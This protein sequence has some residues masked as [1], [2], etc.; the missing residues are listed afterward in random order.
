[1][2]PRSPC[3]SEKMLNFLRNI[4]I[5]KES[6]CAFDGSKLTRTFQSS[7]IYKHEKEYSRTYDDKLHEK[8]VMR[9]A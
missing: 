9:E 2:L 1:M 5:K 8:T 4:A 6:I 7:R 3:K